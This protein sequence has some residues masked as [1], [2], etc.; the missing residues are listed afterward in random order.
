VVYANTYT[1]PLAWTEVVSR[2]SDDVFQNR[3]PGLAVDSEAGDG[4]LLYPQGTDLNLLKFD[5]EQG[6]VVWELP[7]IVTLGPP[8]D[9]TFNYFQVVEDDGSVAVLAPRDNDTVIWFADDAGG[10]SPPTSIRIHTIN[11]AP[12]GD[13]QAFLLDGRQIT[14]VHPDPDGVGTEIHYVDFSSSM[15]AP[16]NVKIVEDNSITGAWHNTAPSYAVF[17]TETMNPSS[18]EVF[19]IKPNAI[20]LVQGDPVSNVVRYGTVPLILFFDGFE[21]AGT[22]FWDNSVP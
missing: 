7:N 4:Y 16:H 14:Y 15:T 2:T 18:A 3:H 12:P 19:Q 9:A 6:S 17:L 20:Y 13:H 1:A 5:V 22:I 10:P 11:G 21:S 8:P